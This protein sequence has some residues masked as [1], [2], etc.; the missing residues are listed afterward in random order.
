VCAYAHPIQRALR[1]LPDGSLEAIY[2]EYS[3]LR[4]QDLEPAF[5]DA[6]QFYWGRTIAFLEDRRLFSS[7]SIGVILPR[8]LV[9]DID[10]MEDWIRAELAYAALRAPDRR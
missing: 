10:T 5:H 1:I 4:S 9:H 3:L 6:G 2:P 7:D 8:Y